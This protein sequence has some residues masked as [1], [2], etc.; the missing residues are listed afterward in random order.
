MGLVRSVIKSV[1]TRVANRVAKNELFEKPGERAPTEPLEPDAKDEPEPPGRGFGGKLAPACSPATTAVIQQAMTPSGRPV[2][3]HHWATWCD[4]CEEEL[5]L[6]QE[7]YEAVGDRVD[8]VGVSWDRFQDGGALDRTL[9]RVREFKQRHLLTWSSLVATDDPDGFFEELGLD[10]E[11]IPQ[12]LVFSAEGELL[13]HIRG[14]MDA[15]AAER[16]RALVS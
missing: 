7:L 11:Q 12:T 6:V 1:L 15:E 14:A 5:P 8:V 2:V 9:K 13:E 16:V 3:V 10:F 4:P